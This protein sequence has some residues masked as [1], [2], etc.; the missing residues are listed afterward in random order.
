MRLRT[1]AAGVAI[2]GTVLGAAIAISDFMPKEPVPPELAQAGSWMPQGP[3]A[4]RNVEILVTLPA[5]AWAEDAPDLGPLPLLQVAFADRPV[6]AIEPPLSTWS[7]DIAPGET[8]DFLLSEAGLAAPDRAEVALA[9]GAEYDLRRLRPGHSVTVASTVDGSPRTVSLAVEDGV[10]IEVV[11]GEQLSTQ[12]VAPDPEIVTLA[13]KAVIDSSIFAALDE[14]GI[15]ARFSVDLAQML[16]GTVD[17]RRELAGGETLRLLWREARVGED[18]IGQPELAF[19]ALEIGGSLYEIVWPDD[20]SGQATIY[21]DGEVLRVFAQPVEGARLSSVFGR[22]THPVF[23]NVRMH[24][25]VDFAAARGTPVQSTA[26]GRVSFIGWRGGYGRVVEIAHGSDTLTRYAHLSAV[27]ED[28]AQGQRVAAGD[29]IG[30]VGATGTATGPNLHY[31]VLVDGRPTDPLSDD[32]LAEAAESE[33]DDTAA[34]SRL[35][36]A[37]ALLNQNLG[38]EIA[39]TTTERL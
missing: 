2:A 35:A 39:E 15:P 10:R 24:T 21:V 25:G 6:R 30:R 26:P 1:L 16:G 28:L 3:E 19:A 11:F 8:L 32:R 20:G 31:E 34:L 9:L 37:R 7:R 13:G 14:A 22:R 38:S 36:E 23:G 29:V 17:F 27:P 4:P 5:T 12:V 18:R 33:A